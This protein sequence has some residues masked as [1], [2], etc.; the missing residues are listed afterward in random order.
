MNDYV[1][2]KYL[3]IRVLDNREDE[4]QRLDP[5]GN[6][7]LGDTQEDDFKEHSHGINTRDENDSH[8]GGYVDNHN[9]DKWART[10]NTNN[11]GGEETRPKNMVLNLFI[12]IND[13]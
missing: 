4:N 2:Q 7:K 5:K 12:K 10:L 8:N 1:L 11:S 9:R 13:D 3:V 6:R